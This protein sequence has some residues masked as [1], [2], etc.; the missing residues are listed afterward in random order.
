MSY[1]KQSL[2]DEIHQSGGKGSYKAES[3][4]ELGGEDANMDNLN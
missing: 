3:K 2:S 4:E 1:L